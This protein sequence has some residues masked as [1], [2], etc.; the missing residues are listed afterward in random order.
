M[1]RLEISC[2][3]RW[4]CIRPE[5]RARFEL[6]QSCDSLRRVVSRR[7]AIIWLMLSLRSAT[8]PDAS[9]VIDRVRSP[10][11]TAVDTSAIARSCV[12]SVDASWFTFSVRPRQ[13]PLTPST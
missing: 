13:V 5:K 7:L 12:V 4:P 10:W 2:R 8:S 9:T 3:S 1:I 11:V 6:S